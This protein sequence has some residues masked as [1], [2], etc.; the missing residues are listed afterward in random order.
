MMLIDLLI[1]AAAAAF[2][3]SF[4]E[5]WM[6]HPLFRGGLSVCLSIIG[7]GTFGYSGGKAVVLSLAAAFVALIMIL[8]GERLATPPAM[9]VDNR[10][11]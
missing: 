1:I 3:V 6:D 8:I 2:V 9:V 7:V 5:R 10:R 4:A 11:R